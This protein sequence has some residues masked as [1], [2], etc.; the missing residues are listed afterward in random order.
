MKTINHLIIPACLGLISAS[1]VKPGSEAS[2]PVEQTAQTETSQKVAAP[3]ASKPADNKLPKSSASATKLFRTP[4]DDISLPTESQ[5]AEG[6]EPSE[7]QEP[8][9]QNQ[10]GPTISI[11]PPAQASSP[12]QP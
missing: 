11:Q 9:Q 3:I 8:A 6:S 4:S 2:D 10:S 7:T 5:I 1:C 12:D